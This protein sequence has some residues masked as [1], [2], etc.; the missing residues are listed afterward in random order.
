M[1]DE[2]VIKSSH[3]SPEN[4]Q[5]YVAGFRKKLGRRSSADRA[6]Q[7][8]DAVQLY[9]RGVPLEHIAAYHN[10]S[11]QTVASDIRLAKETWKE[12]AFMNFDERLSEEIAKISEVEVTAWLA[13]EESRYDKVTVT[14]ETMR[15]T[16]D[17]ERTK[18]VEKREGQ[19]GNPVFLQ[20]VMHAQERRAK[21]LGLDAPIKI[22]H[23]VEQ[24]A[25]RVAQEFG[26]DPKLLLAEARNVVEEWRE[27]ED[28]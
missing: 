24:E 16:E 14:T 13:W 10:V 8:F 4:R 26:I 17:G 5:P 12:Q 19:S 25:E 1:N 6:M 2:S 11:P 20:L 23:L 9:L 21:L 22:N 7:T 28:E 15:G 27:L 3:A 18:R